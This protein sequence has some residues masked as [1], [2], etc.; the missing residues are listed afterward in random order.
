MASDL[1]ILDVLLQRLDGTDMFD[2]AREVV[3]PER[4][5]ALVCQATAPQPMH[6]MPLLKKIILIAAAVILLSSL[7]VTVYASYLGPFEGFVD[8]IK[9]LLGIEVGEM[10]TNG[11]SQLTADKNTRYF[12]NFEVLISE[13]KYSIVY[14]LDLDLADNKP[15]RMFV[16]G[17][18]LCIIAHY[19]NADYTVYS[20]TLPYTEMD[21]TSK[22]PNIERYTVNGL[23][24]YHVPGL[25]MLEY[26]LFYNDCLYVISPDTHADFET[27]ASHIHAEP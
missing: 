17:D 23:T 20:N 12:D 11:D 22:A 8:N 7:G 10:I 27:I 14:P 21:L 6:R 1:T 9:D 13:T 26:Q 19:P 16:A 15:I 5:D 2:H 3:P 24:Y 4:Y 18:M 25:E